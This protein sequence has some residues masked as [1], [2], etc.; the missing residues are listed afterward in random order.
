MMSEVNRYE[1]LSFRDV[2]EDGKNAVMESDT[3]WLVNYE[4]YA[5]LQAECKNWSNQCAA[6]IKECDK[7]AAN[8]SDGLGQLAGAM[9]NRTLDSGSKQAVAYAECAAMVAKFAANMRKG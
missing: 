6:L 8:V 2:C 5:I 7:L 3:G 9:L 1:L 4:D